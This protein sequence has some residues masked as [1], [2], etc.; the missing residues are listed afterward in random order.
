MMMY[1]FQN[2]A[3][4]I[5]EAVILDINP[6]HSQSMSEDATAFLCAVH[7]SMQPLYR[8]G[9]VILADAFS[10][11]SVIRT[12]RILSRLTPERRLQL[13][14][15]WSKSPIG[16]MRDFI[17]FFLTMTLLFYYDSADALRLLGVDMK[18]HRKIQC[19]YAG[20]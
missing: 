1:L 15:E 11:Y 16:V 14:H 20:N 10:L 3:C 9:L 17:R 12:G 19:F 5:A 7:K 8:F 2:T 4:A 18:S 13:M 6:N